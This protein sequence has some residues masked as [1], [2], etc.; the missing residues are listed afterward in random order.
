VSWP[1]DDPR[2]IVRESSGYPIYD[3]GRQGA[4]ERTEIMVMDRAYCHKVVWTSWNN[5]RVMHL[6]LDSQRRVAEAAA[7]EMEVSLA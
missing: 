3:E 2:F 5:P 7:A 1:D 4:V 6:P